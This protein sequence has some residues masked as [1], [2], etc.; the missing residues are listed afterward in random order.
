MATDGSYAILSTGR[1]Y[2]SGRFYVTQQEFS[3]NFVRFDPPAAIPLWQRWAAKLH[4]LEY[5]RRIDH[6]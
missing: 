3:K 6:V 4:H 2:A 5:R 1:R